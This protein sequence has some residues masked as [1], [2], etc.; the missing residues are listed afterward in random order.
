MALPNLPYAQMMDVA[1]NGS[2]ALLGVVGRAFGLGQAETRALT[3]GK[4]PVWFWLTAG[5]AGGVWIGVQVHQRWPSKIPAWF[6]GK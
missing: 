1:Q 2:P 3:N 6:M 4:M 5:L